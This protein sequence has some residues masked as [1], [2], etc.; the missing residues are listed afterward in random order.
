MEHLPGNLPPAPKPS[1]E[2]LDQPTS[3]AEDTW[4]EDEQLRNLGLQAVRTF[5][6]VVGDCF[7]QAVCDLMALN[8]PQAD[9]M[10][11]RQLRDLAIS[12]LQALTP[13]A[14]QERPHLRYRL[15][16]YTSGSVQITR[17]GWS[18]EKTLEAMQEPIRNIIDRLRARPQAPNKAGWA[19]DITIDAVA[20]AL[21]I[22]ITSYSLSNGK[23]NYGDASLRNPERTRLHVLFTAVTTS[24]NGGR[25]G[26]FVPCVPIDPA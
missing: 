26:H 13:L 25:S 3:S 2:V 14:L 4:R 23:T 20:Y 18:S 9:R 21:D 17:E 22:I 24:K 19:D 16:S 12:F 11:P 5:Q 8:N 15:L 7:Y 1:R 6:Y 10:N